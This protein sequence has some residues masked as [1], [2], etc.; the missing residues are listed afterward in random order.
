MYIFFKFPKWFWCATKDETHCHRDVVSIKWYKKSA[1]D[2]AWHGVKCFG[3]RGFGTDYPSL[4]GGQGSFLE[5]GVAE[6]WTKREQLTRTGRK[7]WTFAGAVPLQGSGAREIESHPLWLE[8]RRE[9]V[10]TLGL[11]MRLEVME[12]PLGFIL[13]SWRI[14]A[15]RWETQTMLS[16]PI[17]RQQGLPKALCPSQLGS[18]HL[19]R[20]SN[21][22][23]M[24]LFVSRP[25]DSQVRQ[26][27]LWILTSPLCTCVASSR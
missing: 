3:S 13:V 11:L 2:G 10:A 15:G 20:R 1:S 26:S 8:L 21:T 4:G 23:P 16:L 27:W 7:G 17:Q 18:S 12:K 25:V 24:C 19:P 5:E 9:K 22:T 6:L 14:S